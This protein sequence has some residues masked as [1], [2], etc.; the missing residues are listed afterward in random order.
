MEDAWPHYATYL[1]AIKRWKPDET[2]LLYYLNQV[3]SLLNCHEPIS[4]VVVYYVGAIE[5]NAFVTPTSDKKLALCLPIEEGIMEITLVH[6]LTH[7]VHTYTANLATEWERTIASTILQEGLATQISKYLV[8]GNPD[9]N[10]IEYKEGWLDSNKKEIFQGAYPFLN[11]SSAEAV[12]KFTFGTGTANHEREA[13]FMGWE[14]V[15]LLLNKGMSF[16]EMAHVQEQDIPAF[17]KGH[18]PELT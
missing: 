10:Y 9:Y 5:N 8:P 16:S 18:Y 17:I 11:D 2:Q 7:V 1:E 13:Y 12:E 14:I 15:Q 4:L 6:E 3:K